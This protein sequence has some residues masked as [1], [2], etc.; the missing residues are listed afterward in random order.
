MVHTE[1]YYL[2]QKFEIKKLSREMKIFAF[3]ILANS[4]FRCNGLI[5]YAHIDNNPLG[6][7]EFTGQME[8]LSR[9]VT[10]AV[11]EALFLPM[12]ESVKTGRDDLAYKSL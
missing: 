8:L 12:E 1:K 4:I 6:S 3:S 5:K 10:L 2:S 7:F 9:K 11:P